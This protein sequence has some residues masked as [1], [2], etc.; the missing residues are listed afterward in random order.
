MTTPA[1]IVKG[2]RPQCRHCHRM[3]NLTEV[4][5]ELF[6]RIA[7]QLAEGNRVELPG[8]GILRPK[9]VKE[10]IIRTMPHRKR[11]LVPGWVEVN[12]RATKELKKLLNPN[13]EKARLLE[14]DDKASDTAPTK[15]ATGKR[16]TGKRRQ[17]RA[18]P[19]DP[20]GD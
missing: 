13:R 12:F 2:L 5:E 4:V 9:V 1:R 18:Q 10:R 14:D 16:A 11:K 17:R 7:R 15:R 6:V 8:I 19:A 3:L 20:S